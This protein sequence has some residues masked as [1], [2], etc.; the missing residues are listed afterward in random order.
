VL[1]GVDADDVEPQQRV[2][3]VSWLE[4]EARDPIVDSDRLRK[5]R[6]QLVRV[7]D[8]YGRSRRSQEI[9][10]G[11]GITMPFTSTEHGFAAA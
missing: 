9:V 2:V 5:I 8:R 4:L 3:R 7:V 11:H 1:R 6:Q 10:I